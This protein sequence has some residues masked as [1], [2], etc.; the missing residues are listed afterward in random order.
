MLERIVGNRLTW[1]HP[2][3]CLQDCISDQACL[4]VSVWPAVP[5]TNGAKVEL[6]GKLV[7]HWFYHAVVGLKL[8]VLKEWYSQSTAGHFR[9][10]CVT[11]CQCFANSSSWK[12]CKAFLFFHFKSCVICI[13]I[14]QFSISLWSITTT[15]RW[16]RVL[17]RP[18]TRNVNVH[19]HAGVTIKNKK[20]L[21]TATRGK[22]AIVDTLM[23]LVILHV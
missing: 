14:F 10:K 2:G 1:K 17:Y 16:V 21:H 12:I 15:C 8:N 4:H 7:E 3:C 20:M 19:P 22:I 9:A 6:F 5:R 11:Q 23:F 18:P 13:H